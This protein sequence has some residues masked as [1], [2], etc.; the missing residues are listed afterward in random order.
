MKDNI[1]F[2]QEYH[3]QKEHQDGEEMDESEPLYENG[4]E[5]SAGT[6]STRPSFLRRGVDKARS[7]VKMKASLEDGEEDVEF[8]RVF[9]QGALISQII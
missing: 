9:Q 4:Y 7:L 1:E 8:Q 2:L 6:Q 3:S 5:S